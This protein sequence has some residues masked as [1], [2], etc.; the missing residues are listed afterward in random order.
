MLDPAPAGVDRIVE[1]SF[2]GNVDLDAA[3]A[4]NDAV[5]AAFAT[6]DDRPAF[7]FWPML[8]RNITI[9]LLGS[10][11]FPAS[12]KAAGR[13][14]AHGGRCGRGPGHPVRAPLPLERIAEAHD[15][16][17]AGSRSRVLLTLPG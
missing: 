1:V 13:R 14:R 9:R 17:D 6:R 4:G 16:V 15:Q 11:D 3:V 7:P 12:A 5:I 10:D 2:S 8:F